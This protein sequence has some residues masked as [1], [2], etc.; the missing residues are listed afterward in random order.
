MA[1]GVPPG[2]IFEVDLANYHVPT[3]TI[4]HGREV[5]VELWALLYSQ[6]HVFL[7]DVRLDRAIV[8]EFTPV[9]GSGDTVVPP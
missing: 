9:S 5:R 3:P 4:P 7:A 8:L 1:S 2:L 6:P